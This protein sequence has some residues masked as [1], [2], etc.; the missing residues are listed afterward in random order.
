M[1]FQLHTEP[2]L[3]KNM[4][5]QI[6]DG[7]RIALKGANGSAKQTLIQIDFGQYRTTNRKA[8]PDA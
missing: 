1:K 6:R 5:L 2:A 7:E 3:E 4:N 8:C